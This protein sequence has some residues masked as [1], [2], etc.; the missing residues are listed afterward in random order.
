MSEREE[1]N[2]LIHQLA[3]RLRNHKV[4]YKDGAWEHFAATYGKR[5]RRL[6]PYWSAAAAVLLVSVCSYWF[7]RQSTEVQAPPQMA[8]QSAVQQSARPF[9]Y[10]GNLSDDA[11]PEAAGPE[12]GAVPAVSPTHNAAVE[13]HR[14]DVA[15]QTLPVTPAVVREEALVADTE[16]NPVST[17]D[18][19]PQ[20][21]AASAGPEAELER[22][23]DSTPS[24]LVFN[25]GRDVSSDTYASG[26]TPKS[27]GSMEKWD[28]GLMVSP[29]LTSETV[30]IGGGLTVA[31][32]ISDKFS[33]GSGIAVAQLGLGENAGYRPGYAS[34]QSDLSAAPT[35]PSGD[36][37]VFNGKSE[38]ALDYK[39]EVSLTSSVVTLDIPLDIRYEVAKGFYTSV[40]VSY[41]TVLNEQRTGHYI[42]KINT[43][44]FTNGSSTGADRLAPTEFVY[45]SEKIPA[46]PLRGNGY[47]G[48]MNFSVGKKLP[49]SGKLFLSVEPYFKLPI[50][51][52]SKEEMDFTNGGIRIVT[53]F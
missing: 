29:S 21:L 52:L 35:D 13:Q 25:D 24:D 15:Q 19:E 42:D 11:D 7:I 31:Y 49:I 8:Q 27:G 30:N 6:W 5:R 53:G 38:V 39:R 33:I 10:G 9:E 1:H 36:Y 46:K 28:L 4:P 2:E 16:A 44:T 41:V 18:P 20:R 12:E 22:P 50:G 32:R 14:A 40:G 47:A 3:E 37:P 43:N 26:P 17:P 23:I 34:R 48:F 45:S 51:R